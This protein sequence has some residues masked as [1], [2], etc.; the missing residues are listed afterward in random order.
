[1]SALLLILKILGW[2]VLGLLGLLLL[3]CAVP[4]SARVLWQDGELTVWARVC[5][6]RIGIL[7]G[8][9]S[10]KEAKKDAEQAARGAE[11]EAKKAEKRMDLA[12]LRGYIAGGTR[13]AAYFLSHVR[14]SDVRVLLAPD[15]GDPMRTAFKTGR[16]WAEFGALTALAENT[17]RCVKLADVRITPVFSDA[18]APPEKFS[19]KFSALAGIMIGTFVVFLRRRAAVSAPAGNE[20]KEKDNG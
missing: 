7:P 20:A 3:L 10:E 14:V 15:C 16:A 18:Y 13:A 9:L 17:F 5:G 8:L 11:T 4:V 12:E 19:C 1:M 6:V 2:T